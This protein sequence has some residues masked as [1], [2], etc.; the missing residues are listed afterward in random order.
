MSIPGPGPRTP[1]QFNNHQRGNQ[2]HHGNNQGQ[3]VPGRQGSG[4]ANRPQYQYNNSNNKML[5][6][7]DIDASVTEDEVKEKFNNFRI[8]VSF[9]PKKD[10]N[11]KNAKIVFE[12]PTIAQ[13]ALEM[14]KTRGIQLGGRRVQVDWNKQKQNN[15]M[16]QQ[17]N[18]S[19]MIR[20]QM[21]IQNPNIHQQM[22][23]NNQ[24]FVQHQHM[25]IHEKNQKIPPNNVICISAIPLGIKE[26][27]LKSKFS[28]I[29]PPEKTELRQNPHAMNWFLTYR[30]IEQATQALNEIHSSNIK[31]GDKLVKADY[32]YSK[33]S[34]DEVILPQTIC[35]IPKTNVNGEPTPEI[36][37]PPEVYYSEDTKDGK[38]LFFIND[39]SCKKF[40][41]DQKDNI[42]TKVNRSIY[43]TALHILEKRKVFIDVGKEMSSF[44]PQIRELFEAHGEIIKIEFLNQRGGIVQYKDEQSRNKAFELNHTIFP[45]THTILTVLPYIEKRAE[46]INAGLLQINEL[47]SSITM[48]QLKEH[49]QAYGSVLATSI[50]PTGFDE[51][52]YGF[53]LFELYE[54][55]QA[56]KNKESFP[57]MFL[58]PPIKASDAIYSFTENQL[59][60]PN[61]CLVIYD[62]PLTTTEPE[63]HS[64]CSNY[65]PMISSFVL[66][67]N[68]ANS[69]SAFIYY[70]KPEDAI[71]AFEN[72]T[73]DNKNCDILNGNVLDSSFHL[74]S[75][76]NLFSNWEGLL[77]YILDLPISG[78]PLYGSS[79]IRKL[80]NQISDTYIDAA[81]VR[82]NAS[83][84]APK[85]FGIVLAKDPKSAVYI[86]KILPKKI[87][88]I[89]LAPFR[90]Q[91]KFFEPIQQE[92]P[93][94]KLPNNSHSPRDFIKKF[95]EMNFQSQSELL[96]PYVNKLS[97]N[98]TYTLIN[99]V[100]QN[101]H[102]MIKSK[103]LPWINS[104]LS[105]PS[106]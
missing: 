56:A 71:S 89:R 30:N 8:T 100:E 32:S 50:T 78:S 65:G 25:P 27:E 98:E 37:N 67:D 29:K 16:R 73:K 11:L 13:Q 41:E 38:I 42:K 39:E 81:F 76:I 64:L 7:P 97:V 58:Y 94:Y 53:I 5:F 74:L 63:M 19:N 31:I 57:N 99:L 104:I 87:E 91:Y 24:P 34:N 52:P 83:N 15:P 61:N 1:N 86:S 55:A 23:F 48:K 82:L 4:N 59:S 26:D 106:S 101:K 45:Q 3:R 75:K 49:F 103:L 51:L 105:K 17:S 95:I 14:A 9:V 46:T 102:E 60:A 6:I 20:G 96:L 40:E 33:V 70:L 79:L 35:F 22:Q 80:I 90:G 36:Q 18:H 47:P 88:G 85:G 12:N 62:L 92:T 69:K 44:E 93:Q 54:N 28:I 2:S 68:N 10:S 43:N 66:P 84:G 72:L 77:L 21:L